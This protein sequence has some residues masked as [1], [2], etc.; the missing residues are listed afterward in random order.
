MAIYDSNNAFVGFA[1][2][3]LE[4]HGLIDLANRETGGFWVV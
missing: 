4:A 2:N 1:N 3:I